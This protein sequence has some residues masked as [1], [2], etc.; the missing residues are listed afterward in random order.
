[1][2]ILHITTQKPDSTGSGTYMC[3]IVKGFH[4]LGYEQAIIAGIDKDD[5]RTT[6][7]EGVGYYPVLY[8][9]ETLPFNVLGMSDVMPY[10]STLYKNITRENVDMLKTSFK[11]NIT[12]VIEELKPDF[13]I[14]HHL[15]L[16]T[17]YVREIVD[18]IPV[19]GI[20][21]GTC[22][23]QLMSHD[24]EKEY[25][26][27]N[28]KKLDKVFALHEEQ[29]KE[30]INLFGINADKVQVL[31]TGYDE[32]MFYN[33]NKELK[34]D[35]INI[36]YAGKIAKQKGV[37]SLIKALDKLNYPREILDINIVGDGNDFKEYEEIRS[38]AELSD[39]KI[40]FLG[41]VK[42]N[43]LAEIFRKSHLFLL[44]S[45]F[46]GLPLVVIEAL[47]S[48]CNVVTTDI[49]GVKGWIGET[50]NNSGKIDY[51]ELPGMKAIGVPLEDEIEE[52]ENRLAFSMNQ[53]LKAIIENNCRN[54][55]LEMMDK[56]WAGL[57]S[58][59]ETMIPHN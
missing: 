22:L 45:F 9:T 30:I 50:I 10:K 7:V 59:L 21:H 24:L 49:P 18:N 41:K 57:C 26:L 43:K 3:A 42:Q 2:K 38:L 16:L 56:T 55:R 29:K 15:Y 34:S 53:M 4:K 6:P 44:P 25:I 14:C 17:S 58:R 33:H 46:E 27:S 39:Y 54:R 51:I 13:I 19:V 52:F 28:I 47:A 48:G 23:R 20:S 35:K 40:N 37:K 12:K 32:N 8:N 5:N 36:T 31:G 1:M 11:L